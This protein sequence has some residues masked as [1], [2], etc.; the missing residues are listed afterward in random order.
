M[1]LIQTYSFW[2]LLGITFLI[3]A[4]GFNEI[5]PSLVILRAILI[6]LGFISALFGFSIALDQRNQGKTANSPLALASFGLGL[7]FC[8]ISLAMDKSWDSLIMACNVFAG[9]TFCLALFVLLPLGAKKITAVFLVL[10]HFAGIISAVTSLE[11]PGAPASWVATNL[12]AFYFRHYLTFAYMNNAY[13]FYSPEPGPPT[14]I[15]SKIQYEDGTFLWFKIPSRDESPIQ[16]HYQ[17]MLSITESHNMA[18]NNTPD[19]WDERLQKRNLAGLAHQPQILPLS[20]G[21]SSSFMFRE[22]TEYSKKMV[23]SFALYLTKKF[24]HP[25]KNPQT[26]IDNIKI[27]KVTHGIITASDLARG[28]GPLD[29]TLF[30]PYFLGSF[31]KK[32]NLIDPND[33]FLYFLLPINRSFNPNEPSVLTDSLEIHAGDIKITAGKEG[34][35]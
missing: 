30:Y 14:L 10:F 18:S 21:M 35:K 9:V 26:N 15:W 17:R 6:T 16:M 12:W 27:Y 31:D 8:L 4:I 28:E 22:P 34:G 32:G 24:A 20:K 23:S 33:S 11:P 29:K 2:T 5:S 19:N 13:H 25:D 1:K 7:A 3:F